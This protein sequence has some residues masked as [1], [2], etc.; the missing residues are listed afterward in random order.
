MLQNGF[1]DRFGV[2]GIVESK[3]TL[4]IEAIGCDSSLRNAGFQRHRVPCPFVSHNKDLR[5]ALPVSYPDLHICWR[6]TYRPPKLCKKGKYRPPK[7]NPGVY[8]GNT[9]EHTT[10]PASTAKRFTPKKHVSNTPDIPR[11]LVAASAACSRSAPELAIAAAFSVS[12]SSRKDSLPCEFSAS[13]RAASWPPAPP[14]C[15]QPFQSV[16]TQQQHS[17]R[18]V[19]TNSVRKQTNDANSDTL[20]VMLQ[21]SGIADLCILGL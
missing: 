5:T 14:P 16:N 2:Y 3:Q 12:S 8:I 10:I 11:L 20:V 17:D 18:S 6:G 19:L 13:R 4:A 9:S 1:S 15:T 21:H 7:Q